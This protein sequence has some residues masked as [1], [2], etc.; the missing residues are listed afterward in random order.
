MTPSNHPNQY[1]SIH[2]NPQKTMPTPSP[3]HDIFQSTAATLLHHAEIQNVM[4]TLLDD[5]ETT[6][7][8]NNA[9]SHIHELSS[10]K[11]KLEVSNNELGERRAYDESRTCLLHSMGDVFV[12]ELWD[13]SVKLATLEQFRAKHISKIEQFEELKDQLNRSEELVR[14]LQRTMS[15]NRN[16]YHVEEAKREMKK[17]EEERDM[18]RVEGEVVSGLI[19]RT[20]SSKKT[21]LPAAV[22]EVAKV[23]VPREP[24]ALEKLEEATL[25]EIFSFLDALDVVHTAQINVGFYSRIDA[26][27]GLGGGAGEVGEEKS[28]TATDDNAKPNAAGGDKS[29]S[30][31]TIVKMPE[32]AAVPPPPPA[33]KPKAETPASVPEKTEPSTTTTATSAA[34]TTPPT[35]KEAPSLA[36]VGKGLSNMFSMFGQQP[37]KARPRPLDSDDVSV[38]ST[39]T[40]AT[41]ATA[42]TTGTTTTKTF[43]SMADSMADKLTPSEL[44]VIINMT[45]RLRQ[46][47]KEIKLISTQREDLAARLEGTESVKEFLISKVRDTE[48]SLKKSMDDATKI[49]QQTASDQ[50]VICFLDNRVKELEKIN[51]H[52]KASAKKDQELHSKYK[53]KSEKRQTVLEDMLQFERQQIHNQEKEWKATKK[54]LVK[55]VKHC[56]AQLVAQ[57]AEL[58][59]CRHQNSKLKQALLTMG[60][61]K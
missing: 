24:H 14:S 60:G 61:G 39:N 55:E 31:A 25:L 5:V 26:L 18:Q 44:G 59:S 40:A 51:A 53:S 58:E 47:D 27:F 41:T 37:D 23:A 21:A 10:L 20:N 42:A 36:N 54:V 34:V 48:R 9:L 45:E 52:M 38:T 22:E 30:S 19:E 8:L 15:L 12:G 4:Q 16:A 3:T 17:E 7:T 56:R 13:V 32:K 1:M 50:E 28:T 11:Q 2:H 35:D 43:S 33:P 57:E 29:A 46:K 49:T 6:V